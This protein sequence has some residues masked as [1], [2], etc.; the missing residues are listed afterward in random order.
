MDCNGRQDVIRRILL[1]KEFGFVVVTGS[2]IE[3]SDLM[4]VSGRTLR[5]LDFVLTD[6]HGNQLDLHGLDFSFVMNFVYGEIDA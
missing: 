4:D 3:N 5:A 1:D 2:N 6:S